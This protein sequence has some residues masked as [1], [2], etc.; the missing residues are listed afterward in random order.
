MFFKI[1]EICSLRTNNYKNNI[2]ING[3]MFKNDPAYFIILTPEIKNI[4][5]NIWCLST[6]TR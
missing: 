4:N 2:D 1:I 5:F 6:I 3:I